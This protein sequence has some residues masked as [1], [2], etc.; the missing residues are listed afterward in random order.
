L[1]AYDRIL[2]AFSGGK[3]S[4]AV[5]LRLLEL[6]APPARLE[7]HHH[8]VDGGGPIFMDWA[9]TPGYCE[10]V[11]RVLGLPLYRSYRDGGFWREM[12]RSAERTAPIVFETPSGLSRAGGRSGP[13]GSRLRFPQVTADLSRR[14]C[15]AAL[16]IDVMDAV[17]RNQ[18]RFLGARTLVCTGERAA[19]SPGR[20]RYAVFEPHRSDTRRGERRRRVVDHWRP[21]HGW[22][23]AEVWATLRRHRLAP[24]VAYQLGWPRLSCMTCVFLSP[25]LWAT[26]RV[27]FPQ[28]FAAI[29]AA[30]AATGWTIQRHASIVELADRGQP[31]PSAVGHPDLVRQ[32]EDPVWRLPVRVAGDAWAIPDGAFGAGGGPS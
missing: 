7:L 18:D 5:V 10:A 21:V 8:D 12:Q 15:S 23:E 16:K 27:V 4:L 29:A 28:R 11:A 14:W 32:A 22:S 26:V 24:H 13:L 9:C 25:D 3:D 17:I 30:E 20:A 1:S 19:E 31:H 6:G 2:V